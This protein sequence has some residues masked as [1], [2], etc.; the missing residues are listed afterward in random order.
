MMNL[1]EW[2][3]DMKI[4][5][6]ASFLWALWTIMTLVGCSGDTVAYSGESAN[7]GQSGQAGSMA[8]FAVVDDFLYTLNRSEMMIFSIDEAANPMLFNGLDVGWNIETL[9]PYGNSLFIGAEAGMYIYD[10]SEPSSPMFTSEFTHI[11]SC[12]PV[13]VS[14]STAYVT[15]RSGGNN[16][17]G[18]ANQLEILD[19]SSLSRPQLIKTYMMRNP[20]GL[21]IDGDLLFICDGDAGVKCYN[22]ADPMNIQLVQHIG[23]ITAYD[24]ILTEETMIV[25]AEEGLIQFDKTSFPMKKLS[26]IPIGS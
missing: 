13:V 21:G 15:L 26:T 12:D 20:H 16:C 14:G 6:Y 10:I 1:K 22:V 18:T 25:I 7:A 3:L 24:V 17:W 5:N 19:V 8:R 2:W 4:N 11:R 9:F 23:D